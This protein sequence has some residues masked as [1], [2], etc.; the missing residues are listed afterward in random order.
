MDALLHGSIVPCR[1]TPAAREYEGGP[2]ELFY[3]SI[4]AMPEYTSK[5]F[6]ELRWEDYTVRH[7]QQHTLACLVL[8]HSN[9][10]TQQSSW[11]AMSRF[12]CEMM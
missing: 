1:R 9:T 3:Q 4:S 5:S 7:K 8:H 12:H 10:D 2:H 11:L 6:E